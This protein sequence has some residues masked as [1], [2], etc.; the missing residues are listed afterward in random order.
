[1]DGYPLG[2]GWVEIENA[3]IGWWA[4]LP[5]SSFLTPGD[6]RTKGDDSLRDYVF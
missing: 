6:M 4:S 3:E 2:Y 5:A 1:M